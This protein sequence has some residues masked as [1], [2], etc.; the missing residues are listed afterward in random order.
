LTCLFNDKLLEKTS[1]RRSSE[2]NFFLLFL[3]TVGCYRYYLDFSPLE[4][5]EPRSGDRC[6]ESR[7]GEEEKLSRRFATHNIDD[8]FAALSSQAEKIQEKPLGPG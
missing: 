1:I 4:R 6:G 3:S 2:V 5:R 8:R 7:S